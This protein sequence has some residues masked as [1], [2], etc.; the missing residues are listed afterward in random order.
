VPKPIKLLESIGN[1]G[2]GALI[3]S[4]AILRTNDQN[5]IQLQS[6][7]VY[8]K[9]SPVEHL[10]IFISCPCR[11]TPL[12]RPMLILAC[13]TGVSGLSVNQCQWRKSNKM[14]WW[15]ALKE[16]SWLAAMFF[17]FAKPI[18]GFIA[19]CNFYL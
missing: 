15:P 8:G 19:S 2:N 3:R 10:W 18:M 13:V 9:P 12:Y 11:H 5:F 14:P 17:T 4:T 6:T 16:F 7:G 1:G